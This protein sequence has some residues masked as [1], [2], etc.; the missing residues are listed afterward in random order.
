MIICGAPYYCLELFTIYSGKEP[1]L[2]VLALAGGA[3]VAPS[4]I[5]PWIFLLFWVNWNEPTHDEIRGQRLI[6]RVSN[7]NSPK[8]PIPIATRLLNNQ[9]QWNGR[10]DL[11]PI[12]CK[13]KL[14]VEERRNIR[15]C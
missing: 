10:N 3:A 9:Q 4:S 6:I 12:E 13:E 11:Y 5:D 8:R 7:Q 14:F 15:L 2:Y 1:S